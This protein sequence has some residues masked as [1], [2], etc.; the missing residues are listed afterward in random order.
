MGMMDTD[1]GNSTLY[2]IEI[3]D[4][5]DARWQDWFEGFT[6][7]P[8][9]DGHTLLTGPVRDQSALHGVLKKIS[10]LGLVLISVNPQ[11]R[12]DL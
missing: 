11:P 7:T 10:N 5:L 1:T 12:G 3:D 9:A 4:L 2:Q 6:I 8:L